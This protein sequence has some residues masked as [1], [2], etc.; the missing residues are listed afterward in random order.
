[1]EVENKV[2]FRQV[3][4]RTLFWINFLKLKIKL[5]FFLGIT[6]MTLGLV[7]SLVSKPKYIAFTSFSL[8]EE[9]SSGGLA[10]YLGMASQLG[11]DLVGA[12][13]SVFSGDNIMELIKSRMVTE[14]T[15][16]QK[17]EI[18]GKKQSLADHYLD[19]FELRT[20][21][22]DKGITNLNY[23]KLESGRLGFLQDSMFGIMHK[24]IIKSALQVQRVDKKLS[25]YNIKI[26]T[27][28][29]SFSKEFAEKLLEQL[30]AFYIYTKTQKGMQMV[31]ILEHKA[32]S[33]KLAYENALYSGA[34]FND[35]NRNISRQ[36]VSINSVKK[37]TEAQILGNYYAEV[38]KNLEMTKLTLLKQTPL[39]Q[40]IDVPKYPLEKVRTRKIV[41]MAI[42]GFIFVFFA[43]SYLII[44]KIF[45][46]ILNEKE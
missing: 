11:I 22:E 37:Q 18:G 23:D 34:Q 24:N 6:G 44:K 16:L 40:K 7:Y 25:V 10:G 29:E 8:D 21:L 39:I 33:L 14:R 4:H 13:G 32:D 41:A 9:K 20:E 5:L 3:V 12:G 26:Q 42:G 38:V 43:S 27:T 19:L 17:V 1:M 30:T 35:V 28:N 2:S 31:N 45:A 46:D 36:I 15:L